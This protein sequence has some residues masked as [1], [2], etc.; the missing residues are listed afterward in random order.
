MCFPEFREIKKNSKDW[1]SKIYIK[2]DMHLNAFGHKVVAEK[3]LKVGF[4]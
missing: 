3:I 2:D 4:N 1:I